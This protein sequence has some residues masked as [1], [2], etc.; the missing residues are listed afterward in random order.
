MTINGLERVPVRCVVNH[1]S[2]DPEED[3]SLRT[4]GWQFRFHEPVFEKDREFLQ[5]MKRIRW[6]RYPD[7]QFR[8]LSEQSALELYF[9]FFLKTPEGV[10]AKKVFGGPL[11]ELHANF[12][13]DPF[14]S[15]GSKW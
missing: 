6:A 9:L 13:G 3:A 2:R 1:W 8:V 12:G 4:V 14:S 10:T 11:Q 15:L 7:G 5:R